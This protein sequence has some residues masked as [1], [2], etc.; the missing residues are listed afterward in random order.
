MNP[1][2][3][4]G[5]FYRGN[6]H[7]HSTR[8]DGALD[9]ADVV[10][11]Y[12]EAGY[13]FVALTDH[14]LPR[15]G[16]RVTDTS[17]LRGDG[18]TTLLGAE[19]HGPEL[20]IGGIWHLVAVGLPLDFAAPGAGETGPQLAARAA[21][22][23]AFVGIAHPA[24]YGLTVG[25]VDSLA[26]AAHAVE[27]YNHTCGLLNGRADSWQLADTLLA[28]GRRLTCFAAD[29]AH[30]D[31]PDAFGGWVH[32]RAAA[33]EPD[34]LLAALKAGA[35]YSSQGP[36]IEHLAIEDGVLHVACS[37]VDA[38]WLAGRGPGASRRLGTAMTSVA[39]ELPA[40]AAGH[41]RVTVEDAAGKRAWTNP[42]WLDGGDR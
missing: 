3:A 38:V 8:S 39:L 5:R 23:G 35:Y 36:I 7:T 21:V 2:D 24:W 22:A 15:Y 9:P 32:V 29:D 19:L 12:R 27:V 20:E 1:F 37:P 17:D 30:L 40:G 6:L 11:T 31:R 33:L 41:V 16:C 25:D 4:P 18:F 13:D 26:G 28:Q 14:F 34:A 42:L 10:R